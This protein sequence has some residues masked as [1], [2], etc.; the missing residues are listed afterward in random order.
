MGD[1][2]TC[3]SDT[4]AARTCALGSLARVVEVNGRIH[5]LWRISL[6]IKSFVI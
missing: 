1:C 6:F 2:R 4:L 3:L 5:K